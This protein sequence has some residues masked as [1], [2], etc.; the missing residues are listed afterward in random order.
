MPDHHQHQHQHHH[1]A[2]SPLVARARTSPLGRAVSEGFARPQKRL[3]AWVFYDTHG[4]H[5]YEQITELPEYYPTRTERLIFEQQGADIV[6]AAT[7]HPRPLV[8]ELG[9]GTATKSELL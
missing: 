3:P 6:A 2:S 1:G 5:L 9:A 8:C 7:T 4:S